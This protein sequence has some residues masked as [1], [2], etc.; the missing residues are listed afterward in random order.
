MSDIHNEAFSVVGKPGNTVL[1]SVIWDDLSRQG[2]RCRTL[3]LACKSIAALTCPFIAKL[4]NEDRVC[5][6]NN[7]V[8]SKDLPR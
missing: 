2:G 1:W 3:G 4:L 6:S 7:K 5:R 8:N